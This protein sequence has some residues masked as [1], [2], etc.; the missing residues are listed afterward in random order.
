MQHK[1]QRNE[2]EKNRLKSNKE[3]RLKAQIRNL[4]RVSLK[5]KNSKPVKKSSSYKK[6]VVN[7]P[8]V[9]L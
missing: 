2:Y 5:N 7:S 4:I 3:Y 8:I 9:G 1:E 6:T